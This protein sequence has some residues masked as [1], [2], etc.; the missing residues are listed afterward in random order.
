M[1]N[2]EPEQ[3]DR[4]FAALAHP[5]RRAILEQCS[6]GRQSVADLA[7]PHS[8][9][10]NAISKHIKALESAQLIRRERE[11]NFHRIST[12]A[13]SLVPV[14]DWLSYHSGLWNSSLNA[15]KTKMEKLA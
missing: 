2:L 14:V 13:E 8:M 6:G 5:V 9:S 11:G 15:L 12:S 7:T 3:L 4:V 10:L 1:T